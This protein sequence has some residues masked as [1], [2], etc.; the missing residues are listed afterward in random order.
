ME[1]VAGALLAPFGR[2]V[3]F[4]DSRSLGNGMKVTMRDSFPNF[5]PR[6]KRRCA[7]Y[8]GVALTDKLQLRSIEALVLGAGHQRD[9]SFNR[10]L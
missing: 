6:P 2:L 5:A 9:E 8:A 3:Q 4:G 7:S 10:S 1:N